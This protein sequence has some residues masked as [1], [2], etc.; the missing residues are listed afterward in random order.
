MHNIV[1]LGAGFGGLRGALRLSKKLKRKS[2][3]KIILVDQ[4]SYQ[5]YTPSLYEVA[6]A[7]RG[8]VANRRN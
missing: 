2:E 6:T 8:S 7:Y 5:T 1:I 3:Y 4:N